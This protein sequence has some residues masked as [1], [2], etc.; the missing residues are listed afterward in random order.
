MKNNIVLAFVLGVL[1]LFGLRGVLPEIFESVKL[2]VLLA[3][4]IAGIGGYA[5]GKFSSRR[6]S[7][8]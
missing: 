2:P 7:Q 8:G 1:V 6:T 5:I 3:F 4:T